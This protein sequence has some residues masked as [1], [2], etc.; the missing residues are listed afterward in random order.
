MIVYKITHK[1]SGKCYIGQ[2]RTSLKERWIRHCNPSSECIAISRAL[3]KYGKTAFIIEIIAQYNTLEDLNNAEEY[4]IN[5]YNCLSPNGYNLQT[6]GFS[7]CHTE[8]TK[9][10]ISKT[11][12]GRPRPEEVKRKISIS[13]ALNPLSE[14]SRRKMGLG[15]KGK[16][17]SEEH[18]RKLG[19]S[20]RLN[21]LKKKLT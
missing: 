6:G 14:E 17:R 13:K 3:Q 9:R 7:H 16:I 11:L 5:F 18:R 19:L 20:K 8:E 12:S 2:T 15:Q 21:H 4:Y 10:K 1:L